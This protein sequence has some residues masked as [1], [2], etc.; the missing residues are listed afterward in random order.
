MF[1]SNSYCLEQDQ[2]W[3]FLCCSQIWFGFCVWWKYFWAYWLFAWLIF[4]RS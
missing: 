1:V 4:I 2:E 3:R